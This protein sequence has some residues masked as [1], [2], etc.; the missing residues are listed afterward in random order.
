M[1]VH[2]NGAPTRLVL[3]VSKDGKGYFVHLPPR[4]EET[5][6]SSRLGGGGGGGGGDGDV[7]RSAFQKMTAR[8]AKKHHHHRR[9]RH[10]HHQPTLLTPLEM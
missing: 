8:Q 1:R 2:V 3:R 4:A 9:R 10:H 7:S 5:L 6:R